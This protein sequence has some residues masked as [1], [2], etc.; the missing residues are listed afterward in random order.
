LF[1]YW[2]DRR[3]ELAPEEVRAALSLN[4]WL[5]EYEKML[6]AKQFSIEKTLM[7]GLRGNDPFL[8]DYE[9]KLTLDC[10]VREDDPFYDKDDANEHDWDKHAALMCQVNCLAPLISPN[11]VH[12]PDYWGLGD[13]QDHN[14]IR[15]RGH[16]NP[17]YQARHSYL[18]H[19][20][21][22]HCGVP[23]K[24]LIRIGTI[25]A[26]FEVIHQN[27]VEIDLRGERIVA[28][29]QETFTGKLKEVS[30][31]YQKHSQKE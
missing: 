27:M 12:D 16:S 30:T 13:D 29:R 3:A 22:E 14:D 7:D 31:V 25:C 5:R 17:V 24:H 26:D 15:G 28:K 2:Q 8:V 20:L 6:I 23:F 18:F 21:T 10:Y 4:D 1:A 19:Q 9:I 11:N